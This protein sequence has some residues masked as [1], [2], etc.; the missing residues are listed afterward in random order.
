[1]GF[2]ERFG[3]AASAKSEQLSWGWIDDGHIVGGASAPPFAAKQSYFMVR[4]SEMFIH[5]QRVLW[6]KFYPMVHGFI[7]HGKREFAEVA[8]PG[9]L[10]ELGTANLERLVGLAYPLTTPIVYT[11]AD[12]DLLV[13]LYAV[14]GQD[15]AKVLLASLGQLSSLRSNSARAIA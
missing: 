8:G 7:R 12:I 2:W 5:D 1:M 14:P 3:G 13:G 9:Q 4:L 10:K 6:K 11:G 15:A